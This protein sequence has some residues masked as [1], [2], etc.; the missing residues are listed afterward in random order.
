[1]IDRELMDAISQLLDVKLTNEL[2]PI[3]YEIKSIKEEVRGIRDEVREIKAEVKAGREDIKNLSQTVDSL[4]KRL[5]KD[6]NVQE[7]DIS[8]ICASCLRASA[9]H[10]K[11]SRA[12]M[13]S[14]T[15]SRTSRAATDVLKVLTVK[16][17]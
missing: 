8:R 3:K 17:V 6:E 13:K 15:A 12:S 1:M 11:N 4:E 14:T 9:P 7:N 2:G 5:K 16:K 10:W